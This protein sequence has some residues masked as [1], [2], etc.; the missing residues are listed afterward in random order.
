MKNRLGFNDKNKIDS[1][2][3]FIV[4]TLNRPDYLRRLLGYYSRQNMPWKICIADSSDEKNSILNKK[5]VKSFP[6]LDVDY[7][8][9]FSKKLS[10]IEKMARVMKHVKTEYS[11]IGADDD[12]TTIKGISKA[13]E[14]LDM[15]P[16]YSAAQGSYIRFYAKKD[17]EGNA[18]FYWR[19]IYANKSI[20]ASEAADRLKEHLSDYSPTFYAVQRTETLK[21]SLRE[22]VKFTDDV[23]FAELLQ[24][25]ITLTYGKLK[26][27]DDFYVARESI[28]DSA[29]ALKEGLYSYKKKGTYNSKY[30]R[31]RKCLTK[32]LNNKSGMDMKK[33]EKVVDEAMAG[34]MNKH[35]NGVF[36]MVRSA[37]KDLSITRAIRRVY[38][39]IF[40][41]ERTDIPVYYDDLKEIRKH[42]LSRAEQ[43]L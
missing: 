8:G 31:F 1:R 26:Y 42:V 11:A 22:I 12:F 13:V 24:S 2:C 29:G 14:F 9:G 17:R 37:M 6:D 3:T 5:T 25:L 7:F 30:A 39:A 40:I 10:N 33:A 18:H 16:D 41:P 43:H 23:D 35:Y 27:I 20:A 4:P 32:H 38:G 19:K 15:H 34:Y 21:L 36:M 28:P